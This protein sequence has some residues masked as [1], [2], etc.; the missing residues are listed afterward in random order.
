[1]ERGGNADASCLYEY[2]P[3]R[4]LPCKNKFRSKADD[5][6]IV[7]YTISNIILERISLKQ[8]RCTDDTQGSLA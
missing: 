8:K 6:I 2:E 4:Y 1:V 7:T 3:I 5:C